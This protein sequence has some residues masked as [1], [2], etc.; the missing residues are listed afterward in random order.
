MSRP[1]R[2]PAPLPAGLAGPHGDFVAHLRAE[3][4]LSRHTVDGYGRDSRRFAL[5]LAAAGRASY[6]GAAAEDLRRHL[7]SLRAGG[8]SPR[9]V[10]RAAAALRTFL[11]FLADEG[12]VS[13]DLPRDAALLDAVRASRPLPKIL[14][15][16]EVVAILEAVDAS[17]PEGV[18]DRAFLEV[19][20]ATGARVSEA[21]ALRPGD[22]SI[23]EGI[24][25]LRG[26]G[27]RER[28]VPVGREALR[29][30]GRYVEEA[31][32]ALLGRR[33]DPG[34]L[35]LS[36]RG[37]RLARNS[38]WHLVKRAARRA[39]LSGK[40]TP[41]VLRHAFATHLVEG[42]ADLR[43]VQELLGHARIA[44][45]EIYTHLSTRRLRAVHRRHHPRG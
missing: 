33:P 24:V 11:R 36:R 16:R 28:L 32:P 10:A 23:R 30:I 6:R 20:Y 45:T 7:R 12:K 25:R 31:R 38:A 26:K 9:T 39:G 35:F 17:K 13:E 21:T 42:D 43:S 5:S 1:A 40:T 4:A 41:H 19:L 8:A 44:T 2:P 27:D 37:R 3:R 34:V 14:A 29:W 18:R 15:R 22:L